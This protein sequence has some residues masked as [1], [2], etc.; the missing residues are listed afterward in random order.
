M[1]IV[2]TYF[3]VSNHPAPLPFLSSHQP[4][5]VLTSP[6]GRWQLC[7]EDYNWW[8]R[9]FMCSGSCALYI[10]LYSI[11]YLTKELDIEGTSS[12]LATQRIKL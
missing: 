7:N 1:T 3:Q 2:M 12:S 5:L 4:Y 11:W 10:F 6:F 8:W 9:S